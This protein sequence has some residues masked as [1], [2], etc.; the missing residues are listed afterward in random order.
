M[1]INGKTY[2][3]EDIDVRLPGMG[4]L[5]GIDGIEYSDQKDIELAHGRGSNPRGYGAGNY[6]AEGK[7]TL[8]KEAHRDLIKLA[9]ARGKSI[10][11]LPPFDI[12]VNYA[13][14]DQPTTTDI[15]RGVKIKKQSGSASQGDKSLK[16]EL[17]LV[18]V[19][20]IRWDGHEPN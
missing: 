3:W 17:E 9:K 1:A 20:G 6:S 4:S 12:P 13:N 19:G 16:V 11:T 10:Y 7:L 2:D 15:L 8:S 14:E 18:I 5:V